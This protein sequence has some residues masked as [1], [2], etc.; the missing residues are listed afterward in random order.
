MVEKS[1]RNIIIANKIMNEVD[2]I[3]TFIVDMTFDD[4]VTNE[5]TKRA[6]AMTLIHIGELSN[7][8]T[9]DFKE[10]NKVIPWRKIKALR[11]ITAHN[12]ESLDLR[13]IWTTINEDLPILKQNLQASIY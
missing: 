7:S 10:N 3:Q 13:T 11:N 1:K 2:V 5:I 6:V 8:F 12:Y 9:E 4:Y